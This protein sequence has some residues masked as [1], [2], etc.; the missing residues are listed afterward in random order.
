M[1]SVNR[2][3]LHF[4]DKPIDVFLEEIFIFLQ[5]HSLNGHRLIATPVSLI[6]TPF[7]RRSKRAMRPV[8]RPLYKTMFNPDFLIDNH[9][10][11]NL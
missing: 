3:N 1:Q 7:D 11:V 4:I 10:L 2:S 5:T 9:Y 8:C 6:V